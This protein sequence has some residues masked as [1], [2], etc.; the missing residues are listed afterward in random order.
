[1]QPRRP[2]SFLRGFFSFLF[3][4]C[5]FLLSYYKSSFNK[6]GHSSLNPW[7]TLYTIV[8]IVVAAN[9][10]KTA[11]SASAAK[12]RVCWSPAGIWLARFCSVW[13]RT[14]SLQLPATRT[15]RRVSCDTKRLTPSSLCQDS[16]IGSHCCLRLEAQAFLCPAQIWGIE[17]HSVDLSSHCT[18]LNWQTGSREGFDGDEANPIG[19]FVTWRPTSCS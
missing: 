2:L 8:H 15:L 5:Y 9:W 6:E 16:S 14:K 12:R 3:C 19:A 1:M 13:E 4:C 18:G 17:A 7:F 11:G 10:T